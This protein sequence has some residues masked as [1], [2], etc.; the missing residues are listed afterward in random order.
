MNMYIEHF[1]IDTAFLNSNLNERI[2]M[3]QPEGFVKDNSKVCLLLKS[4]YG[5]KQASRMWNMT[6]HSLLT[7]NNFSQSKCEPCVY[8]KKSNSNLTIVALYV[9]DFYVYTTDKSSIN[10]LHALLQKEF[11]VKNLGPIKNCLGMQ[12][13]RDMSKGTLMLNQSQYIR[14]LLVRY[15]MENCKSVSTPM[16]LNVKLQKSENK[17]LDNNVYKYRELLGSLMYL[18]VCTRPDITYACSQLSQFNHDFGNEHWLAAKRV[19]RYL[20]G[21]LNYSLCFNRTG[22]LNITAFADAD[23]ANNLLDRKSYSGY[24]IRMGANTINWESR[25]QKCVALSSTEAEYLAIS[26]VCKDLSFF[27]N[28]LEEIVNVQGKIVLYN[29]NQSAIKLLLAKEYCHKKTK[30]IDLRYHYVKDLV[31]KDFVNIEYLSTQEMIADVLTKPLCS[32]K[33]RNFINKMNVR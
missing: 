31:Q 11:N 9:D 24:V 8:V 23:W 28:F 1:D 3:E 21:T 12:V 14:T 32:T 26:D 18:S 5:L 25:K 20:A 27:K 22:N 17:L 29:D 13:I 30:H 2:F 19:L 16:A 10:E 33:H 4:I 7:G 15:G 6:V